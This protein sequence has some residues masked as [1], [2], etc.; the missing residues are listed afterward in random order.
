[1]KLVPLF[2][3]KAP[4]SLKVGDELTIPHYWDDKSTQGIVREVPM[5]DKAGEYSEAGD[6]IVLVDVPGKKE[7]VYVF[8][9]GETWE[10]IDGYYS[11]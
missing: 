1:M 10:F 7:P 9:G 8:W 11:A 3:E 6:T 5:V 2:E 4:P